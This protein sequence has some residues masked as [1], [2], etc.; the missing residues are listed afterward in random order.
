MVLEKVEMNTKEKIIVFLLVLGSFANA[1]ITAVKSSLC[2]F[3]SAIPHLRQSL[4]QHPSMP[5]APHPLQR[6]P[7]VSRLLRLRLKRRA[8]LN[9]R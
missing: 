9:G 2:L 5:I 7:L 6:R 3:A 4:R 8:H 1:I